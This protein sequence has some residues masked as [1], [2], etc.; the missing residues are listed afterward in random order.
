MICSK[1]GRQIRISPEEKDCV[2]RLGSIKKICNGCGEVLSAHIYNIDAK[3]ARVNRMQNGICT[4]CGKAKVTE[5]Y[6][7]CERC[8]MICARERLW[9]RAIQPKKEMTKKRKGY[10]LDEISKMAKEKGIS[11]G[12]MVAILE[13]RMND[14]PLLTEKEW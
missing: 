2:R 5:G 12:Q 11:Y 10:S 13:G 8:R 14:M 1:C 9:T 7:T 3:A 6:I 4:Q